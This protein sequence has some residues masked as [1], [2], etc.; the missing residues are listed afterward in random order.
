MNACRSCPSG[1]DISGTA[2]CWNGTVD[3][4]QNTVASACAHAV[5]HWCRHEFVVLRRSL[6]GHRRAADLRSTAGLMQL[7][8]AGRVR[9]FLRN[10]GRCES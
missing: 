9:Q 1:T 5:E 2:G 10:T 4:A 7:I 8:P 3:S 6:V